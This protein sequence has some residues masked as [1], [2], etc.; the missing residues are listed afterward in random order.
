[1]C[2]FAVMLA[3]NG[4]KADLSVVDKMTTSIRHRGP[5]DEGRYVEGP[6]GFGFRRLSIL[7]LSLSGHQPM[8]SDDGQQVMVF[9]GE[10]YNYLELR[11]ELEA[12]GH[13]FKSS[14]DTEVL[15]H[16]YRE[17]GSTCLDKLNGMWAFVIF[18]KKKRKFFGARD[19]FGIKPLYRYQGRDHVFFAS[20]I[21]AILASGY[22]AMKTNWSIAS[23]FLLQGR[24]DEGKETFYEGIEQIPPGTAFE[25]NLD[26]GSNEWHLWSLENIPQMS[27][28]DPPRDFYDVFED[29]VKLRMRSDVP[30]GVCLS[31]GLD[32]TSIISL[33]AKLRADPKY[34]PG[35]S[36][37]AFSY[38]SA[39]FDESLYIADT[40]EQTQ[41]EINRLGINPSGLWNQL[42]QV[43]GYHDEPLHSATALIGFNLMALA[44]NNGVKV[45][46]N[47]QGA[48]ET[49]GGYHSYFPNYWTSLLRSGRVGETFSEIK[50]FCVEHGGN[51]RD[52]FLKTLRRFYR[53]ELGRLSSYRK[54]A[55]LRKHNTYAKDP[56]FS[57]DLSKQLNLGDRGY[58][59]E[60]LNT[61][62]RYS[63]EYRPL[64]LYLRIEDRNSMAHSVE[65]RLPFLDY[66][67]VSLVWKLPVEWKMR[68]PLNKY[69]L[70]ASMRG[71]IPESVRSR[72]DKM[73][74]PT[75][76]RQWFANQW[77]EPMRDLLASQE[78]HQRGI[79]DVDF[80]QKELDRHRNGE[81]DASRK[82]FRVAQFEVLA[83]LWKSSAN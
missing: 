13:R 46:L 15:L 66:R 74:F 22:Y 59:N 52:L 50:A 43:L 68:G 79:Y 83:Q 32:S 72:I 54:I 37:Q 48:D 60:A 49:I 62:L 20:E 64:P 44:A 7:D 12:L 75:S 11:A 24:L 6:V 58:M 1:M 77:Y 47:G 82:L 78:A 73:G 16:A 71:H 51:A 28:S 4:E 53:S 31:G 35:K 63:V 9:N 19:R 27:I 70:R 45:V 65:A 56:F 26:T 80:I 57:P 42:T 14:G 30:V 55:N 25:F 40:I 33:M 38:V 67:L 41:A 10:I 34:L 18:D 81:I 8:L 69:V 29:A 2:G 23:K 5:D 76:V 36:L 39:E 17:W 21:K 61:A 3:L